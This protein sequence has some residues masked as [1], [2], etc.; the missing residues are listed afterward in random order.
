MAAGL[1]GLSYFDGDLDH[2]RLIAEV[3]G[4]LNKML[5]GCYSLTAAAITHAGLASPGEVYSIRD[6]FQVSLPRQTRIWHTKF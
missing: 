2:V 5:H 1:P 4:A 6:G 3:T